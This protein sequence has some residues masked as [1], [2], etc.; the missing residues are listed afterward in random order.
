MTRLRPG[1]DRGDRYDAERD[2]TIGSLQRE[3]VD[4]QRCPD[5]G[6]RVELDVSAHSVE[7]ACSAR[8]GWGK[9]VCG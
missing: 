2:A 8:C 1:V 9:E 3:H 7:A 5:C 6:S 4:G